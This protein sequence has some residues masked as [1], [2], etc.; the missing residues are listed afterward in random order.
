[1]RTRTHGLDDGKNN[2]PVR[3]S[4]ACCRK[5]IGPLTAQQDADALA[6]HPPLSSRGARP[7]GTCGRHSRQSAPADL[8]AIPPIRGMAGLAG[9]R[10]DAGQTADSGTPV[11]A[12]RSAISWEMPVNRPW[13]VDGLVGEPLVDRGHDIFPNTKR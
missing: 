3:V 1:M 12:T 9:D 7:D 11:G 8:S 2:R 10:F 5:P 6:A 4:L 13:A